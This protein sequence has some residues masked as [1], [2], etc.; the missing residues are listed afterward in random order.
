MATRA[1]LAALMLVLPGGVVLAEVD[2]LEDAVSKAYY[3]AE[4][5]LQAGKDRREIADRLKPMVEKHPTSP[6]YKLASEFLADLTESARNPPK[7]DGEPE[8][9]LAD[10]RIEFYLVRIAENWGTPLKEFLKKEP[11]DP[12]SQLLAADRKVIERL[13]PLL[14]DKAPT[15]VPNQRFTNGSGLNPQ[16]RVCDVALAI[17]EYHAQCRFHYDTIYGTYLHQLPADRREAVA[18]RVREWWT[19]NKDKSVAAGVRAQ[20]P[21]AASYPEKVWMA[22][23]LIRLGEGRKTDD[24]EYGLTVLR[25]M[26]KQNRRGHVGGYVADVLAE[27]GDTSAVDLFYDEWKS[28][29]GRPGLMHDSKIAFYLCAHGKRREWELLHAIALEEI[30]AGKGPGE[31]AVWACVVNSGKADKNPFA[32]PVLGLAI[33]QTKDTGSRS[34][35]GAGGQSFSYADTAIEHLQKQVGKDF[36]YKRAGTAEERM[37]AIRK[38]QQWWDE[39]G[40]AK[41][42]FDYI[43]TNMMPKEK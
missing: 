1:V 30:R 42:T 11:K 4:A 29:L 5:D 37:A 27:L 15:R 21:H 16:P 34:V 43:G 13:I 25:D 40:K 14:T 32:I 20:I 8:A 36:G 6:Y 33:G 38:A 18:K 41:Y 17:I 22:K 7:A 9:R 12:A 39:E 3:A 23:T 2:P 26:L 35:D 24:K 10:T 19:E 28:W 31:G